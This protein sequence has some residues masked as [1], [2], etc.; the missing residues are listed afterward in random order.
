MELKLKYKDYKKCQSSYAPI[1]VDSY[2]HANP[3]YNINH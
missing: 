2:F 1:T 3:H